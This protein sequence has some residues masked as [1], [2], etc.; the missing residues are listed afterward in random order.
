M[1][2]VTDT[3][4]WAELTQVMIKLYVF[5]KGQKKRD[6]AECNSNLFRLWCALE[7]AYSEVVF[8]KFPGLFC[9][10]MNFIHKY[11][12]FSGFSV[13]RT[14][15]LSIL[16]PWMWREFLGKYRQ[17]DNYVHVITGWGGVGL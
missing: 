11:G 1:L 3:P 5:M 16:F 10:T 14:M 2:L 13:R 6:P 9:I 12:L 17:L 15:S 4:G 7:N 8:N